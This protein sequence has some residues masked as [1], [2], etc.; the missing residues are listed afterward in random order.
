VCKHLWIHTTHEPSVCDYFT[1]IYVSCLI[2]LG[3]FKI[4]RSPQLSTL[5]HYKY[6]SMLTLFS[7]F[8]ILLPLPLRL[9]YLHRLW[10]LISREGVRTGTR[11]VFSD[12]RIG[13]LGAVP[14]RVDLEYEASE[15]DSRR[16]R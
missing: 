11:R 8:L 13:G 1:F 12:G 3:R 2:N 16:G 5:I 6:F 14:E 4:S 7:S 10:S 9:Y 15:G